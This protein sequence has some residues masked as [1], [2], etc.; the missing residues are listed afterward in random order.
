MPIS[1]DFF[2]NF[3]D[4]ELVKLKKKE[5][6]P[7]IDEVKN[8]FVKEHIVIYG[9][10]A[11]NTYLPKKLQFYDKYDIPDYDGYHV[12]AKNQSI[13]LIN[14]LK[15]QKYE[16]LMV[17]HAIHDGTYKVSWIF[18]DIAD[19]TRVNKHDYNRIVETSHR[20]KRSGLLLVDINLLKSSAYIELGMPKS[21]S[22]RW[23]K[24]YKR[25]SLLETTHTLKSTVRVENLF[26]DTIPEALRDLVEQIYSYISVSKKP[27][28][29]FDAVRYYLNIGETQNN[30]RHNIRFYND[31]FT[32]IEIL[33]DDIY[34]TVNSITQLL[35]KIKILDEKSGKHV[36]IEYD[37][38]VNNKSELVPANIEFVV[39]NIASR[40]K[41]SVLKIH[42]VSNKCVSVISSKTSMFI[43]GSIFFLL[44]VYYYTL[45]A[46]SD[47]S[48]KEIYKA[49]INRLLGAIDESKFT[50]QCYGFNKS[51][52]VI[53]KSRALKNFKGVVAKS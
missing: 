36:H 33:S 2:E 6:T 30:K 12:D 35:G 50:M 46:S 25:V 4:E 16:F 11:M 39:Y 49:V 34:D 53:K 51:V 37:K 45:F 38:I 41:Y 43:Y 18:K 28:V 17:K 32:L 23:S 20:D 9:G 48:E 3:K 42:D 1:E 19:I 14:L 44:Y 26:N 10:T 31:S 29:G 13:A 24:V 5:I 40:K 15:K 7:V 21:S 52:S 47:R 8:F 22:F 27:L